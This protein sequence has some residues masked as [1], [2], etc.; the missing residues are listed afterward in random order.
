[1]RHWREPVTAD[2]AGSHQRPRS[3]ALLGL[4][5][6]SW[7]HWTEEFAASPTVPW[8]GSRPL[9]EPEGPPARE[10]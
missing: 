10:A 6:L 5:Y 1:M 2:A 4:L 3:P 9:S 7:R 8:R